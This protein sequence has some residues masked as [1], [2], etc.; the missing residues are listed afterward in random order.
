MAAVTQYISENW[1]AKRI[2]EEIAAAKYWASQRGVLLVCTEF[3]ALRVGPDAKSRQKWLTD[4]RY[5]FER[6]AIGWTVWDY[7][8]V[9]G[10]ATA[11]NGRVIPGDQ[12][13]VPLDPSNP[14]RLF[15][16]KLLHALGLTR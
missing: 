13:I 6:N 1:Q 2:Q 14:K 12:A 3:G 10:I 15:N 4:T 9:F 16:D 11:T 7:A 8:D 5:A